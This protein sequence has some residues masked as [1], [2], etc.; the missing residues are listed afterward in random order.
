MDNRVGELLLL[1]SI[2]KERAKVVADCGLGMNTI[3]YFHNNSYDKLD[4]K[5]RRRMARVLKKVP[6]VEW[7]N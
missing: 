5:S 6:R 7:R 4:K 3:C 1:L 2:S